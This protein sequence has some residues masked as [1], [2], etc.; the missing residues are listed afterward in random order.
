MVYNFWSIGTQILLK[1]YNYGPLVYD[2]FYWQD[3]VL[4]L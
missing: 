2:S 1:Q 3:T 4:I